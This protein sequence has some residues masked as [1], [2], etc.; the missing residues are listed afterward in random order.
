M[1][2]KISVAVVIL[3]AIAAITF[4]FATKKEDATPPIPTRQ[5]PETQSS[6]SDRKVP[7][8]AAPLPPAAVAA[9]AEDKAARPTLEDLLAIS[10]VELEKPLRFYPPI[11]DPQHFV[12]ISGLVVDQNGYPIDAAAILA[13]P[14]SGW[15]T[16]PGAG[17]L[18][19]ASTSGADGA[20]KIGGIQRGGRYWI[21]AA[22][23]GYADGSRGDSSNSPIM[24]EAGKDVSGIDFRLA[25]G[26]TV[27]GRLLT[28]SGAPVPDGVVYSMSLTGATGMSLD[29]RYSARTDSKG[30]FSLGFD[31]KDTGSVT[32]LRAVSALH[33]TGAFPDVVIQ[34]GR[35]IELRLATPAVIH[36]VVR[37]NR[38]HQEASARIT[39]FGSKGVSALHPETGDSRTRQSFAGT[40]IAVCDNEGRYAVEVDAGVS[41]ESDIQVHRP[42][43]T[44]VQNMNTTRRRDQ[45]D[46][47][48]LGETREYNPVV[49]ADV[50]I[51]R[52]RIIGTPSL[53]PFDSYILMVDISAMLD[54]KRA[55]NGIMNEQGG[56]E[57][58]VPSEPGEYTVQARYNM[59]S[60]VTGEVSKPITLS[61]G[62]EAE[63]DITLPEPQYFAVRAVAADGTPLSDVAVNFLTPENGTFTTNY[64]TNAEGRLEKITPMPP[65][66]GVRMY[67][68]KPGYATT[69]GPQYEDQHSGTIHP[70]EVIVMLPGAGFEADLVGTDG[71]PVASA[72]LSIMIVN[73][74][75]QSCP[76]SATT[77]ASGHF[78]IVDQAPADVVDISIVNA[79]GGQTWSER[80]HTLEAGAIANLG[81]IAPAQ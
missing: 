25:S 5:M 56:Y 57:L 13:T 51:V 18:S 58:Q 37:N 7:D 8:L 78:T 55:G 47:L 81:S 59:F 75:G 35:T 16:L 36:G 50:I 73:R 32:A 67:L 21:S 74:D 77:D 41:Y 38:G 48:E 65:D 45:I 23:S 44:Q 1:K 80:Q 53:R 62:D 63:L 71:E 66:S 28:A 70:E 64:R 68:E 6:E 43:G 31:E 46:E 61:T 2:A 12:S 3:C 40:F 79:D 34:S 4:V 17:A 29:Q 72:P 22:K 42:N 60:D 39:F 20:Y 52:G 76:L 14:S 30:Y 33:G 10:R 69:W 19:Y 49:D 54:G 15:G 9:S 26:T 27:T 24:I 11:T